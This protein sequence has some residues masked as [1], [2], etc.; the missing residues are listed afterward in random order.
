MPPNANTNNRPEV[1][2]EEVG[3][4]LEALERDLEKVR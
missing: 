1:D 4:L 3:K 2:L